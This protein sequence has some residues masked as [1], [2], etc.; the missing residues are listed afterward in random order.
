M[1]PISQLSTSTVSFQKPQAAAKPRDADG[2]HD[3]TTPAQAARAAAAKAAAPTLA[4]TGT[5]GRNLNT[6][7]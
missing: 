7:A 3:G 6:Y 2:D 5:V 1:S 4:Q